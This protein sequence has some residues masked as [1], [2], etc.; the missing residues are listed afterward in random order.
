MFDRSTSNFCQIHSV[1]DYRDRKHLK[2]SIAESLI[3]NRIQTLVATN[4]ITEKSLL[5]SPL[6]SCI[7][8]FDRL[9]R[10]LNEKIFAPNLLF[11]WVLPSK[12]RLA[13][14]DIT[15]SN[16][17]IFVSRTKNVK[18]WYILIFHVRILHFLYYRHLHITW[19]RDRS[20][21]YILW[22]KNHYHAQFF[23][24]TL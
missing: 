7:N 18:R 22:K 19:K 24:I 5:F 15:N 16:A 2:G 17:V 3:M 1:A 11:K 12:L 23:V 10:Y 6:F 13:R 4:L 9:M 20:L 14:R 21:S 8:P